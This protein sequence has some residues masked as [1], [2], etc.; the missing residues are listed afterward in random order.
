MSPQYHGLCTATKKKTRNVR[1]Y[2]ATRSVSYVVL[3]LGRI[4]GVLSASL[5]LLAQEDPV[6]APAELST[7]L[8][9]TSSALNL[10]SNSSNA[11]ADTSESVT[12]SVPSLSEWARTRPTTRS[13]TRDPARAPRCPTRTAQRGLQRGQGGGQEGVR[14]GSGGGQVHQLLAAQHVLRNDPKS[15]L[16][17]SLAVEAKRASKPIRLSLR[18]IAPTLAAFSPSSTCIFPKQEPIA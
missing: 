1:L 16:A 2:Y 15:A 14:R 18:G 11:G 8:S 9:F 3:Y 6:R 12:V 13:S 10:V 4:S 5:P 7:L 17:S